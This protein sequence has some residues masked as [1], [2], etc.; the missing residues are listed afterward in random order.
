MVIE[1]EDFH[2]RNISKIVFS[3]FTSIYVSILMVILLEKDAL[4]T[5]TF[6]RLGATQVNS[7]LTHTSWD[8]IEE[9]NF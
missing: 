5:S 6:Y 3:I 8:K 7:E 9:V 1:V 2:H 4:L